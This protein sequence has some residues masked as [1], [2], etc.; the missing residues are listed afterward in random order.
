MYNLSYSIKILRSIYPVIY[1]LDK[2]RN[3][4]QVSSFLPDENGW[5]EIKMYLDKADK[6]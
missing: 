6:G 2:D 3:V 1:F 5:N 4:H